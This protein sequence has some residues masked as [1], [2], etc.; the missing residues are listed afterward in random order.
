MAISR[1][2]FLITLLLVALAHGLLLSWLVF[3]EQSQPLPELPPPVQI[4][5]APLAQESVEAIQPTPQPV[6]QPVLPPPQLKPEP[7]VE[8]PPPVPI[9]EPIA[10]LSPAIEPEPEVASQPVSEPVETVTDVDPL[11][12]TQPVTAKADTPTPDRQASIEYEQ[13]IRALLEKHKEYPSRAKRMRIQGEALLALTLDRHG[14]PQSVSLARDSGHRLLDKAVL[15]M[16]EKAK[17]FPALPDEDPRQQV[18]L[19]VPVVFAPY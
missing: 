7:V 14:Q 5:L 13:M 12:P 19:V 4:T 9:P 6:P 3:P 15:A 10:E 2:H 16:V 17:P 11:P 18:S 1:R 8:T